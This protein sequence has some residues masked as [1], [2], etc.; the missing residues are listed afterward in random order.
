MDTELYNILIDLYDEVNKILKDPDI[1]SYTEW[2]NRR[3]KKLC[4]FLLEK[5]K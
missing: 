5:Y 4:D 2:K 1:N 3:Y